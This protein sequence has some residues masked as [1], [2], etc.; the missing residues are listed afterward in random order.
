MATTFSYDIGI[1]SIGSAVEKDN[2]LVYMGTRVFNEAISAKEARLNRSSRRTT[3]RKTWRKNQMKEAFIDFGVI[4]EKDFKMPGFMSFTTNNQYLKRPIDNSVYHLR[5][6]ALSEK[7]TKRELLLAL[8]NICGTRGHFLLETIDFSKGGISFEM[9]KDRFYQ[10]T[11]SYV[12]FVQ[13]T[14]EFEE[15]L[16]KVFDGNINNNEIKTIVSKNRFTIDEESESI[17]IEFLRLLCNYKVKLQKI[18]EKLDDFSSSVNVEDLKKQDELGS[19]YEEVIELYDLSNVARILKNYNYLCELAVD[20]MDEYR[21]SQQ[22]GE[23]AYDVMKESIKSKAANNASHSRSVKNLANSF[24]NGLYVKEASEILRKQQEYYPE[25]T[26][27]FIEVCTSII[28]ARIPYYIG[29]LDENAKNAWVVK[30]QNFKYS[31]EDTMK[32]SNDKAVN[33][34]ESIKK[35]KLNMISRCTY[36]HDKYALPKGSF[37]AETFSILNE[38]NIL[39]AED[40]NGNDYYLT[41]DDKIKVFDSLF[42]KNKIVKFSDICDVLD[43]GYFG[44]SNKSNKTTKFNNSYSV[45]LDIIRIDGKFCFNSIVEIFTDKE[46]VE[47]LED[48]ILDINLYNEEKSK[49][50]VLINK[51]NYN[52]NDSK[53]LSRINSNGF[54]A[55][56]KEIIMDETMNEKGETMLDILFSDNVS[57]YKNEQM[58]IIYNATDLNGVKREYFS[59]KYFKKLEKNNGKLTI[60]LLIEDG[61]PFIPISRPTIRALNE[62][63]KLY[64]AMIDAFGVPDKVVIETARDLKDSSREGLRPEKFRDTAKKLYEYVQ[65]KSKEKKIKF[66]LEQW[67]DIDDYVE[68]NKLKIDLYIRQ[69]GIDLL[70]GKRININN[71]S[72]YEVDHILPRG[73]GDD[74]KDDKMLVSKLSNS[75]KGDRLPLMYIEDPN[76]PQGETVS[77]SQFIRTVKELF[78]L[79]LISEEKRNRLLLDS[80]PAL[81]EFVNRNLVDTRYIIREFMA[82]L[83]AYSKYNN[84][85]S[86]IV[87][88]KSAYTNLYR[89]AFNLKKNRDF[90]VQHHAHD[91]ALLI[92]AEKTLSKYYPDYGKGKIKPELYF[93][94]VNKIKG[95]NSDEENKK[96][97]RIMYERTFNEKWYEHDSFIGQIKHQVP[98]YSIKVE[99]N[100]KG[101]FF[102]ATIYKQEKRNENSVL[103]ILGVNNDKRVFGSVD[104]VAVDFYKFVNDKK[105][106][107]HIAIHIPKFIVSPDGQINKELYKKLITDYYKVDELLEDGEINEKFYRLRVFKNDLIFDTQT[108]CPYI[109]NVGSI[110]NKTMEVKYLNV[111][112]YNSIYDNA[113]YLRKKIT[114]KFNLRNKEQPDGIEYKEL[115]ISELITFLCNEKLLIFDTKKE[116]T[117]FKLLEKCKNIN[118]LSET[119]V[120]LSKV[121]NRPFTPPKVFDQIKPTANNKLISKNPDAEYVKIKSNV[122][123][124][125]FSNNNKGKLIIQSPKEKRGAYKMIKRE[126]F[127]WK[128]GK[129]DV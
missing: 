91:A 9:Y 24:P 79:E 7:V 4:D 2:K 99:K 70:T 58:T 105:E 40:K 43:I 23:E 69:N 66:N 29:P 76:T 90:G 128:I 13:D 65:S 98:F 57:T 10:L 109:F 119:I 60:D 94:F 5:K 47:K 55:F 121:I 63:I 21:K 41:R 27:R 89:K 86:S 38:L 3:R 124:I 42:L 44:P 56:S 104:C 87:G 73:F 62:C 78:E 19:F 83:N 16:K 81:T 45:Y 115:I 46:K 37:I 77:S 32:Q 113:D 48:L 75:R 95:E 102:D 71:L 17:L 31:Y 74:S 125:R 22:E 122:L 114:K 33:E 35:W 11:D 101:K 51:H 52:M 93:S 127:S 26:E 30:N 129:V 120:F 126:K 20:N 50:D 106:R 34:A 36:L 54:F 14:N 6:R 112:S 123:G 116:K 28:S 82:I 96:F 8:Y 39:S 64:E 1:A 97:I 15:V 103:S 111:F 84:Y 61:K 80:Y 18:S 88:I 67:K 12:D 107:Q 92:V 72:N 110:A 108:N 85:N 100:W 49:L 59:N 68:K 25:I 118:E 117:I 53:K